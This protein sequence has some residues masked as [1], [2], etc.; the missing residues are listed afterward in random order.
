M[1]ITVWHLV[2]EYVDIRAN[3]KKR[4][5]VLDAACLHYILE[6]EIALNVCA[7]CSYASLV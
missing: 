3:L 6:V 1:R 2:H 5:L 7:K 4:R